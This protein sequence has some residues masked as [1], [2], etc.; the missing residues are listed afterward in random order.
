MLKNKKIVC[1][2]TARQGSKGIKNKNI[3]I[4]GG[5]PLIL[6]PI[7]ASK[8]SKYVD[9]VFVSTDS[10]KYQSIARKFGAKT[11]FL[12]PKNLSGDKVS[13]YSVIKHF[14][15]YLKNNNLDFDILLLL[16]PTSPFTSS[17]DIDNSIKKLI[18]NYKKADGLVS[19][20]KLDK[21]DRKSIFEIKN[22]LIV[23]KKN[24]KKN[25]N[26]LRRQDQKNEYFL[27]G[28]LYISK[29]SSLKKNKGFISNKTIT[30]LFQ[31]WKSLEIDDKE[32]LII[33]KAISKYILKN[34]I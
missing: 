27:D 21:F 31:K 16:E 10:K 29:I 32:D 6:F 14:L 5:K 22:K 34:N 17:K 23:L 3:K 20:S 12:R 4:I 33:I 25:L 11:P 9:E 18:K 30:I 7:K 24:N 15:N 26:F 1:L 28:S 19:V 2:I 8:K 13:S